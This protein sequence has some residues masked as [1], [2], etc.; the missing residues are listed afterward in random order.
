MSI[1]VEVAS[2][3]DREKRDLARDL[4]IQSELSYM[5]KQKGAKPKTISMFTL[6]GGSRGTIRVPYVYAASKFRGHPEFDRD[7]PSLPLESTSTLRVH[8]ESI[9]REALVHLNTYRTVQLDLYTGCGK[10]LISSYIGC[11]IKMPIVVLH[12]IGVLSE[13]WRSTFETHTNATVWVV[14][15]KILPVSQSP[16]D[17]IISMIGRVSKIP[18]DF[19][20]RV[21]LLIMD[22][23]HKLCI[24]TAVEPILSFRPAY[25]IGC[26][27]TPERED[28]MHKMMNSILG[29]HRVHRPLEIKFNVINVYTGIII[30]GE[31][32]KDGTLDWASVNREKAFSEARNTLIHN[33]VM[34]NL[35]HKILVLTLM[36][37]HSTII[38]ESLIEA[39]VNSSIM[40][41]LKKS[42]SD[43][44][45]LVG[46][47]SKLGTGFDE[48]SA[49]IDFNG[50]R[51]DTL[52]L[53][54]SIKSLSLITQIMGRVFRSDNPTVIDLCDEMPTLHKHHK[55]RNKWY[56]E[57][58]A[59][60]EHVSL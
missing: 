57:N 52:I 38:H 25:I 9:V 40:I 56:E 14:G 58:G 29:I 43:A 33:M 26:S 11:K 44:N 59:S 22:E 35:S 39:G 16:P 60:I 54:A 41:G 18:Q 45:V 28:G 27:A 55:I 53:V 24:P 50:V 5:Q 42:Y 34:S 49:C 17:V 47:I 12:N 15:D 4:A 20:D 48:L 6:T 19:I 2:M 36:K 30:K 37:E 23:T 32:N 1:S 3:T 8:Q 10:T 13:Q 31:L 46:T 21:G 51:I 7:Y